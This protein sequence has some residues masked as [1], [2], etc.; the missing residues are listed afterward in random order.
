MSYLRGI[1]AGPAIGNSEWKFGC[2]DGLVAVVYKN[3]EGETPV[4]T[5]IGPVDLNKGTMC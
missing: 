5:E 4:R 1:S 2:K 3:D